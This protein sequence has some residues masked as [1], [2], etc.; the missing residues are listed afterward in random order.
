V[1]TIKNNLEQFLQNRAPYL[2]L[3]LT[4]AF[5]VLFIADSRAQFGY[6]KIDDD[7]LTEF[8]VVD[9]FSRPHFNRVEGVVLQGGAFVRHQKFWP[10][11]TTIQGAYGIKYRNWQYDLAMQHWFTFTNQDFLFKAD[12]FR[13]TTTR[14]NWKIG[15]FE[16]SVAGVL[17]REDFYNYYTR[18]GWKVLCENR[19]FGVHHSRIEYAEYDYISMPVNTNFAGT[20]YVGNKKFRPNPAIV[21]G[22]ERS[23]R[24]MFLVDSRDNLFF[25]SRG[26]YFEGIVEK[27]M[28]DFHTAGFFLTSAHYIPT[29]RK[30]KLVLNAQAGFRQGSLAPQHLLS[31]GGI[32]TLC[33]YP[34]FYRT[35][36]NL[37]YARITWDF[38]GELSRILPLERIP[39]GEA[40]S[41]AIFVECGDAWH[42]QN[43]KRSLFEGLNTHD[44]LTD[45]GLSLILADGIFRIDFARQILHD[46]D[47]WRITLRFLTKV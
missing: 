29:F 37:V 9:F 18:E 11:I 10:V 4:A 42:S 43:V 15:R 23:V 31:I 6:N 26:V 34:E 46:Q 7:P 30:Q 39:T 14:D 25:P 22:R 35:G 12:Y 33:A 20:L 44:I 45:A 28:G 36:Q 5:L 24:F 47:D 17:L 40:A 32:G 27:T 13:E 21:E 19:I 16:N 38:A 41:V 1:S 2:H 3:L 8:Q